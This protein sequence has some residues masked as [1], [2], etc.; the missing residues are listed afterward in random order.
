MHMLK[1]NILEILS[2]NSNDLQVVNLELPL[3]FKVKDD[4]LSTDNTILYTVRDEETCHDRDISYI[5]TH[6]PVKPFES[7][8]KLEDIEKTWIEACS[9]MARLTDSV[10][11][12][13]R[14]IYCL[15]VLVFF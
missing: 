7:S 4:N 14:A 10:L 5:P 8:S 13:P 12:A 9:E 6:L 11:F 2:L 1:L 3:W 15:Q